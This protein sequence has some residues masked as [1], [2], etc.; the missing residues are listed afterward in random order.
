MTLVWPQTDKMIRSSLETMF[1]SLFSLVKVVVCTFIA[2]AST[3]SS[4]GSS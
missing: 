2:V 4:I 3:E 1:N